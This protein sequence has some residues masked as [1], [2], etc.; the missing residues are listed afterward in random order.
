[1]SLQADQQDQ[2]V[3]ILGYLA[4]ASAALAGQQATQSFAA[5]TL[6]DAMYAQT[7]RIDGPD[8]T[9]RPNALHGVDKIVANVEAAV[10]A[11][12]ALPSDGLPSTGAPSD[13]PS[14]S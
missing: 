5:Y 13:A 2:N 3:V 10:K 14:D 9:S 11:I 6:E 7:Q 1:M 12:K 8:T 4:K